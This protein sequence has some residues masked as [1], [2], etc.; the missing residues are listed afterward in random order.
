M[1]DSRKGSV[2]VVGVLAVV[3]C[4]RVG[5]IS[6]QRRDAFVAS[7]DHPAIAYSRGPVTDPVFQLNR[8]IQNSTVRLQFDAAN[9]YLRSVL[10]AL[11]VP[12]ESQ[13][14]VFSETS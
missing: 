3:T 1:S 4:V 6:A 14:L 7:R 5:V 9:G 11:D 8:R 12:I 2:I 13:S 10:A